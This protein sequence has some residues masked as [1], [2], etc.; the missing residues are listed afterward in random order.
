MWEDA[1]RIDAAVGC[2]TCAEQRMAVL[3]WFDPGEGPFPQYEHEYVWCRTC[4]T[5]YDPNHDNIVLGNSTL[6][7]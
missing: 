6:G 3:D 4:G 2:P 5:G 1:G 7:I